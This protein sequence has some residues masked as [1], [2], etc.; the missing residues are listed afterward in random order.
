ME[1][2]TQPDQNT[3]KNSQK[4]GAEYSPK[5]VDKP[6]K[7]V[8]ERAVQVKPCKRVRKAKGNVVRTMGSVDLAIFKRLS[9]VLYNRWSKSINSKEMALLALKKL[10]L[11]LGR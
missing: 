1:D 3:T 2:Q 7:R 9:S 11:S 8:R 10:E 6:A 5:R 4:A